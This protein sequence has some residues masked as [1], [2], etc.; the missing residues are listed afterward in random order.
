MP[1]CLKK[2]TATG[3]SSFQKGIVEPSEEDTWY[4]LLMFTLALS[5]I[6]S[7]SFCIERVWNSSSPGKLFYNIYVYPI[8]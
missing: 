3:I 2:M 6:R 8:W 1:I 4:Y 7:T 5:N